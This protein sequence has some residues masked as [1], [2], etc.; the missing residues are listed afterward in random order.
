MI[1]RLLLVTTGTAL[2]LAAVVQGGELFQLRWRPTRH[3][4]AALAVGML[5]GVFSTTALTVP[6]GSFAYGMIL[7][8]LIFGLCGFTLPWA[9]VLLVEKGTLVE[10]GIHKN[11]WVLSLLVSFL[12]AGASVYGILQ[13]ADLSRYDPKQLLGAALSLN[14]GGLFELFLY[15][16]FIHLRLRKAFGSLPAIVG[17]AAVYSLWHVGT[18]LPLHAEPM[19]ALTML[20]LVGVMC[21][22]VFAITYNCLAIWPFFF[23]AGVMYDFIVNLD[24]PEE[25]GG[26]PTWPIFGWALALSVPWTIWRYSR[27]RG[28][29]ERSHPTM[30][31]S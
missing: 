13:R 21:Q 3:T 14:V 6:R 23:T 31:S 8:C 20:F 25:V 26:T 22:S 1:D 10:L 29:A 11:R 5:A 15:Y 27:V 24:L 30:G 28:V 7:W 18:E 12:F 9:Y 16:G 4:A 19:A 17:T 2:G